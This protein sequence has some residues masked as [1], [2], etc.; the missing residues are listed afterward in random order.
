MDVNDSYFYKISSAQVDSKPLNYA[1][2]Q[3]SNCTCQMNWIE[4]NCFY[5]KK[6]GTPTRKNSL[7]CSNLMESSCR[8]AIPTPCIII[9]NTAGGRQGMEPGSPLAGCTLRPPREETRD[10]PIEKF[11]SR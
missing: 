10:A 9:K 1:A 5:R 7:K 4:R 6:F 8:S 3:L 2:I 11:K